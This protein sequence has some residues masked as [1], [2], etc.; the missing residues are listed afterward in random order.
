MTPFIVAE[1]S[2][3]WIDG[4][5]ANGDPRLL[6]QI[7]EQVIEHNRIRGYRLHSF[8]LHRAITR[9]REDTSRAELNETIIAVFEDLEQPV[10]VASPSSL[11]LSPDN[12]GW[13]DTREKAE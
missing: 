6:A 3:N 7:F 13:G 2:K 9:W 10:S 1:I 4:R 5:P 8:Q 12:V 11:S